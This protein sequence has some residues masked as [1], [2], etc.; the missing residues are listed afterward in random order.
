MPCEGKL[1]AQLCTE[2]A[3]SALAGRPVEVLGEGGVDCFIIFV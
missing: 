2:P 3:C 1:Q